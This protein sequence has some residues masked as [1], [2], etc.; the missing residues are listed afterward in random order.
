M[1]LTNTYE[2]QFPPSTLT[3][4]GLI[5]RLHIAGQRGL[6]MDKDNYYYH[7][8]AVVNDFIQRISLAASNKLGSMQSLLDQTRAVERLKAWTENLEDWVR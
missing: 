8:D 3:R 4:H 7:Q 1:P 2:S 6:S 5:H